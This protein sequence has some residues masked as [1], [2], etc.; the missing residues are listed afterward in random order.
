MDG[1]MDGWMDGGVRPNHTS[2]VNWLLPVMIIM[3]DHDQIMK[4]HQLI[5]ITA[6]NL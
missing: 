2:Q 6:H 5:T 4:Y 1:W 3:I